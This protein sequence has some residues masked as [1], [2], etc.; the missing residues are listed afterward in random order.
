MVIN[1]QNQDNLELS[2]LP[3]LVIILSILLQQFFSLLFFFTN[4]IFSTKSILRNK[5][6]SRKMALYS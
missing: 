1:K 5:T 2:I 6:N 3:T 4:L